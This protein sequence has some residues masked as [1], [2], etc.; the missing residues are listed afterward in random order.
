MRS[1]P[2]TKRD[3]TEVHSL[4]GKF[5][6]NKETKSKYSVQVMLIMRLLFFPLTLDN[7]TVKVEVPL[8]DCSLGACITNSGAGLIMT[9]VW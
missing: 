5:A 7:F 8:P 2:Q 1:A 3:Q 9:A 4:S 6:L